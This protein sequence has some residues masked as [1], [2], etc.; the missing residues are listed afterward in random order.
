MY[1]S[2]FVVADRILMGTGDF[3][4]SN[5]L[6]YRS[7][8]AAEM[9]GCLASLQFINKLFVNN[10]DSA[11]IE[12]ATDRDCL[13]VIR[14]IEMETKLLSNNTKLHPIVREFLSI[15][16]KRSSSLKF[17]KFDTHQ[18]D[19]KSFDQLTLFEQLNVA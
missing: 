19:I 14:K 4:S 5:T 9:C 1:S 11:K 18:D 7:A 12:L 2:F 13:G 10:D 6:Y 15:K 16:L 3:I 17:I 8:C